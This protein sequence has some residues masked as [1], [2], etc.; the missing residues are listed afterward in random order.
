METELHIYKNKIIVFCILKFA[1]LDNSR[2][3]N[4]ALGNENE[5]DRVTKAEKTVS[6]PTH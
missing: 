5:D 6:S 2:K 4:S 1:Y 3:E